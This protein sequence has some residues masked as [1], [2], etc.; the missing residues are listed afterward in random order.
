MSFDWLPLAASLGPTLQTMTLHLLVRNSLS[1][2]LAL[3]HCYSF[4]HFGRA[5]LVGAGP[6]VPGHATPQAWRAIDT[7]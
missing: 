3:A 4:H 6:R 1:W 5:G 7:N 2:T